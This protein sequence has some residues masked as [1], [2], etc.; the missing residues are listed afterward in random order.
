MP[1]SQATY[2]YLNNHHSHERLQILHR[3]REK[4]EWFPISLCSDL[5]R[6]KLHHEEH[7]AILHATQSKQRLVF[8]DYITSQIGHWDQNLAAAALWEW[9]LRSDC[10]MWHRTL[11]LSTSTLSTQ[12]IRYTLADLAWYGGGYALLEHLVNTEGMEEMSVAYHA[13]LCF[14]ALQFGIRSERLIRLAKDAFK[15]DS[16]HPSVAPEKTMPY[17]LAYLYRYENAWL[18]EHNSSQGLSSIWSQFTK[19]LID[20]KTVDKDLKA[21][22]SLREKDFKKADQKT[23]MRCWPSIWDRHH[24]T[25]EHL[26]F[27]FKVMAEHPWQEITHWEFIS[28]IPQATMMEALRTIEDPKAYILALNLAGSFL[29]IEKQTEFIDKLRLVLQHAADPSLLLS[30]V[31]PR[32]SA[33]LNTSGNSSTFSKI[34]AERQIMIKAFREGSSSEIQGLGIWEK[35]FSPDEANRQNFFAM[36]YNGKQLEEVKG[37]DFWASMTN[38]WLKPTP[39]KIDSLAQMARQEPHLFH[40]CFIDTLGRFKGADNA[41][42]KLLDFIRSKEEPILRSIVYALQGIGTVRASQE[43]V[44]FLTRPNINAMLQ[45]EIAQLLKERDVTHLQAELRSALNDLHFRTMTDSLHIGLHDAI[46]SLLLIDEPSKAQRIMGSD[47][48]TPTTADLDSLLEQKIKRY[49]EL[50]SEVKRALRTAQFFHI[51]VEKVKDR[52][53]TIDLSPTID[54]QYKALEICFREKFEDAAGELIRKGTLQRKLDIIGYARPIPQAMDDYEMYIENLP[55]VNTIPFF[56]RFKLRKMLRAICQYRPGKRFTLDGLKAFALFFIC[57][58]RKDC[59]FGLGDLFHIK[60]MSSD[61]LLLYCK[62]LH[63]FQDFRNRAAHEGFHPDASNNLDSIWEST[64]AIIEGMFIIADG[65][66]ESVSP[67]ILLKSS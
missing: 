27:A 2:E 22:L 64:A 46:T 61:Q 52:L 24:L 43:L 16:A 31:L 28:G 10:I 1:E 29:D 14:R 51:Q 40:L 21:L 3:M 30:T 54:M 17:Y 37:N 8:E 47:S 4:E 33:L 38:A 11:P 36:A 35:E 49:Q 23:F 26:C 48:S 42:L 50:S 45:L 53:E 62:E 5:L 12:R 6:L 56:S 20:E 59:R 32:Y 65:L 18:K 58:S 13:L 57:F 44:A 67:K 60:N 34:F 25:S 19:S 41:A 66:E 15:N 9:A 7:I 55:I 63:V 39:E